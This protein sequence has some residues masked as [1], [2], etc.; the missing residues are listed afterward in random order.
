MPRA[1]RLPETTS[2]LSC[3]V[4]MARD[5]ASD[6]RIV[7]IKRS[8]LLQFPNFVSSFPH[9]PVQSMHLSALCSSGLDPSQQLISFLV[10]VLCSYQPSSKSQSLAQKSLV[11]S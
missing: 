5:Q 4:C 10:E 11:I 9:F 8:H 7:Y 2:F 1:A 3:L 6:S